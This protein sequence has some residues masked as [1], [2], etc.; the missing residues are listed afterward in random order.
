MMA[1]TMEAEIMVAVMVVAMVSSG[2]CDDE[3]EDHGG[4]VGS[5]D[6]DS[7]GHSCCFA[8]CE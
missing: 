8:I 6:K 1:V 4:N 3:G 2:V 7:N 5:D